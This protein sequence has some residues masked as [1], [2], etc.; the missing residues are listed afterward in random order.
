MGAGIRVE[1][2]GRADQLELLAAN[3]G[4]CVYVTG[5]TVRDLLLKQTPKDIDLVST[6]TTKEV[7][8]TASLQ[9]F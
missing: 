9:S 5:G 7:R 6:A 1:G 4:H 8:R 3:A 2:A